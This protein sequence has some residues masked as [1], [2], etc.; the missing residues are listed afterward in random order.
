VP[1]DTSPA[2]RRAGRLARALAGRRLVLAY[3]ALAALYALPPWTV[4]Y[5]PITDAGAHVYNAWVLHGL[6]TG[7]APPRI[8]EL[9]ELNASPVPNWMGHAV[10]ALLMAVASPGAAEKV[11]LSGYV[12]L[13]LGG[14]WR[15]VSAAGPADAEPTERWHALLAF[16]FAYHLLLLRGFYNFSLGMALLPWIVALWWR[17]RRRLGWRPALGLHLLLLAC[18][19][20]HPL[21][22]ALALLSIALLWLVGLGGVSWRQRLGQV[23]VLAPQLVL[24]LWYLTRGGSGRPGGG[25]PWAR[26][27]AFFGQLDVLV[28]A[29]GAQRWPALALALLFVTLLARTLWVRGAP[30]APRRDEDAFLLLAAFAFAL[31]LL[32][33]ASMGGAL[34]VKQ[35]L[36]LAPWLL[37]LPGLATRLG[38]DARRAATAALLLSGLL[39]L[40]VL[41]HWY[42]LHG[43]EVEVYVAGLASVPSGAGVAPLH[44]HRPRP[45]HPTSHAAG[46]AAV[47]QDLVYLD[48]FEARRGYFPVRYRAGAR[49]PRMALASRSPSHYQVARN[50]P[51]V[52]AIYTW[53]MPPG[54]PLR[55]QI[56]AWYRPA[57]RSGDGELWLRRERPIVK[58]SREQRERR[59]RRRSQPVD[60]GPGSTPPAVGDDGADPPRGHALDPQLGG[61]GGG[62]DTQR[63]ESRSARRVPRPHQRD[64]V[65]AP[66]HE[67]LRAPRPAVDHH[68]ERE[69]L[70]L[71]RLGSGEAPRGTPR[72]RLRRAA[73]GPDMDVAH[74]RR[75]VSP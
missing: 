47:A 24:P 61:R 1:H 42:R 57:A 73:L 3:F 20:S 16:P 65:L 62:R 70:P 18:W 33:P 11:L 48:N 36:S 23:A 37:V 31:Y 68:G 43:G 6:V 51:L 17:H 32:A 69:Q 22:Y 67:Q 58:P 59:L 46:Y 45:T 26:L 41:L 25:W 2:P 63:L 10:M 39:H 75:P 29:D 12:A 71:A 55:R 66:A 4:R 21:P 15:L 54:A 40:G 35:R 30:G 8:A 19:F 74:E 44:F 28:F 13:F 64:G 5:Q 34:M 53:R 52:E 50:W 49:L 60:G 9:H 56:V 14:V 27:L 7:T 38:T 72:Q